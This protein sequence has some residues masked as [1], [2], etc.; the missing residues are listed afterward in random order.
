MK[1]G[2]N[3]TRLGTEVKRGIPSFSKKFI[4]GVAKRVETVDLLVQA[5]LYQTA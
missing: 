4:E 5:Y 3:K 1:T 2:E